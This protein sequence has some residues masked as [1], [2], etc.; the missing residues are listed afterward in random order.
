MAKW[1]VSA[2]VWAL[3]S[4]GAFELKFYALE[5]HV[6]GRGGGGVEGGWGGGGG[7]GEWGSRKVGWVCELRLWAKG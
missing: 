3:A 4:S 7:G 5:L 1:E 2:V 6:G